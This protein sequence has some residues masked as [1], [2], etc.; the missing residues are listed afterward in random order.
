[1]GILPEF[2]GIAV[3]DYLKSYYAYH[4]CRNA[5]CGAHLMRELIFLFEVEKKE[6]AHQML[7]LLVATNNRVK[8]AR[9]RGKTRLSTRTKNQLE[10][11]YDDIC[12]NANRC[13]PRNTERKAK[14]GRIAQSKSRNL[15]DRLIDRKDEILLFMRDF[16]VPFDNNE[17]ERS[18]R[19]T[20]VQQK[21]SGCFRSREGGEMF[22]RIRSYISTVKKNAVTVI[23]ALEQALMNDPIMPALDKPV[24]PGI[25][26]NA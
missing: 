23:G 9:E 18:F 12:E 17:A 15:L 20:K 26:N 8:E 10:S 14:R 25:I 6:W 11:A 21:I 2:N 13:E 3:H 1:M 5:L 16:R 19:M 24:L 7:N 4:R 22:C